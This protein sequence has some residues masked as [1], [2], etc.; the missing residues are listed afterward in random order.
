MIPPFEDTGLLPPGVH[1]ADFSELSERF[2]WNEHRRGLLN[3]LRAALR[4]LHAAACSAVYVDGSFVTS[5]DYPKDFDAAYDVTGMDSSKLDRVF[6]NLGNGR[7]AQKVKFQGE[8]FP[9]HYVAGRGLAF[10]EFFQIDRDG[11][12]KGIVRID[13]GSAL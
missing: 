7:A 10:V 3:G 11:R 6:F 5:V 4:A 8:L 9:A 13:P 1:D 12:A 2:G